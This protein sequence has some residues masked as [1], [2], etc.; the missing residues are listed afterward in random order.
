M[1]VSGRE[2]RAVLTIG[3]LV[4]DERVAPARTGESSDGIE[5]PEC[6]FTEDPFPATRNGKAWR[7]PFARSENDEGRLRRPELSGV[8]FSGF[9][10]DRT[11][12]GPERER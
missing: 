12:T 9:G 2:K 11:G 1:D 4:R 7:P 10:S 6:T 3:P 8:E 5:L